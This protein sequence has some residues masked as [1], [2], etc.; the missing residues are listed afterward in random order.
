MWRRLVV[1]SEA[2]KRDDTTLTPEETMS[3]RND[4]AEA[5][6]AAAEEWRSALDAVGSALDDLNDLERDNAVPPVLLIR[7]EGLSP[8]F[9]L[10]SRLEDLAEDLRNW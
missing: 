2:G 5:L 1:S 3:K 7:A 6:T 8:D 4:I 10:P 9:A